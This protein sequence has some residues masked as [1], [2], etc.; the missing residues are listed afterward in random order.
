VMPQI[1]RACSGASR[2]ARVVLA[3][4]SV[5]SRRSLPMARFR[6]A[7]ITRGALPVWTVEASSAKTTSLTWWLAFSIL[8]PH[9]PEVSLLTH[10]GTA[11]QNEGAAKLDG[12]TGMVWRVCS[13]RLPSPVRST[14]PFAALY[15][16]TL[17][18]AP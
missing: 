3:M 11:G 4:L 6:K 18:S 9:D 2:I 5:P 14:P 8:R 13:G 16:Q 17:F 10:W 15:L 7:A 12:P 1:Q